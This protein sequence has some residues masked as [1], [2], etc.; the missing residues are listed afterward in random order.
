MAKCPCHNDRTPSLSIKDGA[1]ELIVH[2]HGGCSYRAVKDELRRQG[3][4]EPLGTVVTFRPTI[5]PNTRTLT[6]AR[7]LWE[8]RR[9]ISGTP[10]ETYLRQSR[11]CSADIPSVFG[12]LPPT[13]RYPHPTMIAAFGVGK[14][15]AGVHL[16]YLKADGSGKAAVVAQ[17]ITL[18][19]GSTGH[20]IVI[21][22]PTTGLLIAEGI[23]D[24]LSGYQA[25]GLG[26]WA[27]GSAG[28]MPA[29]ADVVPNDV[30]TVS[31][32]RHPDSAGIA[33]AAALTERLV[34]RGIEV[35][36]EPI[37]APSIR[38]PLQ[39]ND[40]INTTRAFPGSG[41]TVGVA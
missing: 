22:P 10:V 19:Q 24:A 7:M 35:L 30:E 14:E 2:C 37:R 29:L 12:Y 38:Q 13:E 15:I 33:G 34:G 25:T 27:A 8:R 5:E 4:L 6:A 9:P 18:G 1:R 39:N 3:L 28:R 26:A 36:C 31:I 21:A 23:E 40:N 32:L 16:T 20:P 41:K 17:K 11:G